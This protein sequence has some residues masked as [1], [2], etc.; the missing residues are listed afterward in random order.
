M[1]K[2]ENNKLEMEGQADDLLYE[3]EE[4]MRG[5]IGCFK[6]EKKQKAVA[7]LLLDSVLF[8]AIPDDKMR[9]ST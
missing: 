5:F 2:M 9:E 7:K 6:D 8:A 4:I 3:I 1:I